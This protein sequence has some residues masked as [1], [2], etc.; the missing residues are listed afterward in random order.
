VG[1]EHGYSLVELLVVVAMIAAVMLVTL[2][3]L[4][5]LMP[6][7]RIR[8]AATEAA[9]AMRMARQRA[10]TMRTPWRI[11]I[12]AGGERYRFYQLESPYADISD[13]TKWVEIRRDGRTTDVGKDDW[14]RPSAV[15]VQNAAKTFNDVV[16]P[17][18]GGVDLI[19]LRDGTVADNAPCSGGAKLT[20]TPEPGI[21]MSVDSN[22]VR[23]NRYTI[24]VS[25]AG[26]VT[27]T[28]SKV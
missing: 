2:P 26:S 8:S 12:D 14:F 1:K 13:A 20:F 23:F 24:T 10:V 15:N 28:P 11:S 21:I 25:Q 6:Q 19:F 7:Y 18:G 27:V 4:M 9:G 3:A 16:C 5:Q 22:L 17:A